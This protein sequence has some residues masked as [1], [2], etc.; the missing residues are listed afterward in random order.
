MEF[1][2]IFFLVDK[3]MI[4]SVEVDFE[5]IELISDEDVLIGFD[6][7]L[8]FEL[9]NLCV[10]SYRVGLENGDLLVEF[11]DLLLFV[12]ELLVGLVSFVGESLYF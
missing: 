7:D 8:M 2:F 5:F 10:I 1:I 11:V 4:E 9:F 12:F 6:F 3:I